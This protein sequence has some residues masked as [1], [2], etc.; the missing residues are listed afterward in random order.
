MADIKLEP[1]EANHL[2]Q[3]SLLPSFSPLQEHKSG[4]SLSYHNILSFAITHRYV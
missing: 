2:S 4:V 1:Q 3:D